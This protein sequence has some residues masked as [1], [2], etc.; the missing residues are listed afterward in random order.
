MENCKNSRKSRTVTGEIRKDRGHCHKTQ[1]PFLLSLSINH[2]PLGAAHSESDPF[3]QS[4]FCS[5]YLR[6]PSE[7]V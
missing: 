1:Q 7:K 6:T 5:Y 3:F 4:N 2:H